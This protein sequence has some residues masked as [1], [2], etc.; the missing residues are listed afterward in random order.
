[1]SSFANVPAGRGEHPVRLVAISANQLAAS[2]AFY[3]KVFGWRV[4]PLT[5]EW[6]AVI[7]P[8][9]PLVALR[10]KV[11]EGFPGVVPFIGVKDVEAHLARVVAA[12][13]AVQKEPWR[14]AMVGTMARFTDASGTLWGLTDA[15]VPGG[16]P[17]MAMP[18]GDNP[19][20][21]AGAV[22]SLEMYAADGEAAGRF[23]GE[24]FGWGTAPTMPQ[25]VAFDPG[26]GLPGVF[27]SHTPSLPAV[28]YVYCADV[29]AKLGEIDAAGGSRMGDP[30]SAPGMGTFGYF[31]DPSGTT[32]GLIGP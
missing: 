22:C 23:F 14:I 28:A 29:A 15:S 10:G 11:G 4:Q 13:G 17:P 8:A 6:S 27:Q 2:G 9:G 31:K 21:P 30:M 12:G 19:K 20:P 25:F 16:T 24:H 7:P 32:M 26:A 3:A 1:M 5:D 18:F